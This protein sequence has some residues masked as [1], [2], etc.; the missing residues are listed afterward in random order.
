MRVGAGRAWKLSRKLCFGLLLICAIA[1]VIRSSGEASSDS[2]PLKHTI[3]K[4]RLHQQNTVNSAGIRIRAD[5][6]AYVTTWGKATVAR[7]KPFNSIDLAGTFSEGKLFAFESSG[8]IKWEFDPGL[9]SDF[10]GNILRHFGTIESA[11]AIDPD[12]DSRLIFGRGD[13]RLF[14]VEDRAEGSG[15]KL[16]EYDTTADCSWGKYLG[17]PVRGGQIFC[18]PAIGPDGLVYFGITRNPG[19]ATALYAV[20]KETGALRWRYPRK[21]SLATSKMVMNPLVSGDLVYFAAG[22][23]LYA[24]R[25]GASQQTLKPVWELDVKRAD[26]GASGDAFFGNPVLNGSSLYV[27]ALDQWQAWTGNTARLY[28]IDAASGALRWS[29]PFV[30]AEPVMHGPVFGRDSGMFIGCGDSTKTTLGALTGSLDCLIDTGALARTDWTKPF[31]GPVARPT[32]SASGTVYC[33][34]KGDPR[35]SSYQPATVYSFAAGGAL[36]WGPLSLDAPTAATPISIGPD[37]TLYLA[38]APCQDLT[39]DTINKDVMVYLI[40]ER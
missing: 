10:D 36:R 4:I 22:T 35:S 40:R 33:I 16:W 2:A 14:C 26:P 8:R 34:M 11:P 3:R 13:G 15:R 5:G 39:A 32:V 6:T 21:G 23:K 28:A 9:A 1:R 31:D 19:T 38:D 18:A 29:A 25:L 20:D 27:A 12:D 17:Y 30:S 37:G 7:K 24:F